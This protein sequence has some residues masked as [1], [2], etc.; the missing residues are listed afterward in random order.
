MT[1]K[2]YSDLFHIC[3]DLRI[4]ITKLKQIWLILNNILN[5]FR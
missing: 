5:Y 3:P 4:I 2:F 1:I